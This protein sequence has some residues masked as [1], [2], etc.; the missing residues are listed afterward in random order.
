MSKHLLRPR[1]PKLLP[2]EG[3]GKKVLIFNYVPVF[4]IPLVTIVTGITSVVAIV[5][6]VYTLKRQRYAFETTIWNTALMRLSQLYDQ[7]AQDDDLARL[8]EEPVDKEGNHLPH[9][10]H[11]SPKQRVW[12]ANLCM[13]LEQIYVAISGASGESQRAWRQFLTNKLNKPIIR[14]VFLQDARQSADYHKGFLEF[15]CGNVE[16]VN[17]RIQCSGGAIKKEVI[18]SVLEVPLPARSKAL[19]A[20]G[21]SA[22][23]F[24]KEDFLF[25]KEMYSDSQVKR[26]MYMIPMEDAETL[27]KHFQDDGKRAIFTVTLNE[28]PVGGFTIL[29]ETDTRGTFGII[30]H[31]P[32]RAQGL[33]SSIMRLVECQA[34]EMGLL[35]LRADVYSDNI[36]SVR[37]LEKAGLRPVVWF[38]KNLD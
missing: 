29:K 26:Q 4:R 30:V 37:L 7:A 28:T 11:L 3:R 8:I 33:G 31:K 10:V 18:K 25:W 38:E 32:F 36:N 15:V 12:L 13:A 17:G 20:S 24:S 34:K 19:D 27:M 35:T 9:T 22:H 21:L 5:L 1:I 23:P 14:S 6:S 2:Y 16:T